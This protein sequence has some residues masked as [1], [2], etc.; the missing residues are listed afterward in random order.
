MKF[1]GFRVKP[2]DR[3][4]SLMTS[5]NDFLF[6]GSTE[7]FKFVVVASD[8]AEANLIAQHALGEI[9]FTWD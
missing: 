3:G 9:N 1:K 4:L 2:D 5:D 8:K 7:K 6:N